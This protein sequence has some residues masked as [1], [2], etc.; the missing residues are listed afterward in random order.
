MRGRVL[1]PEILDDLPADDPRAIR[2]RRD[3]RMINA[4]MRSYPWFER[5]LRK[6]PDA[7][8]RGV[9]EIG[10]G[11]GGLSSRLDAIAD[12]T[13]VDLVSRPD[14]VAKDVD[15]KSG[16]VFEILPVL[17]AGAV[18]ANLFIHHFEKQP[19]QD[20]A[21]AIEQTG[22]D[23]ILLAEPLRTTRSHLTGGALFPLV[24]DVTW[25]DMH[26]SIDAGF[27]PGELPALF[28]DDWEWEEKT[29]FLGGLRTIGRRRK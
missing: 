17:N 8:A 28:S 15:W 26:V 12:V 19:L 4:M 11:D 16:D 9:I 6:C 18:V 14:G 3:L 20:L 2:S 1:V 25:H 7:L 22:S 24:N 23:L 5:E 27:R 29:T 10:A 21:D 13:A